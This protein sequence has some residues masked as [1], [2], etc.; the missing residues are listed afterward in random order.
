PGPSND[1]RDA[2]HGKP[3]RFGVTERFSV[4]LKPGNAGEGRTSI[5]DRHIRGEEPGDWV[6]YRDPIH[7]LVDGAA[8][9]ITIVVA[10]SKDVQTP[11]GGKNE[12]PK[13]EPRF[14]RTKHHLGGDDLFVVGKHLGASGRC[15]L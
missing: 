1:R 14:N 6:T 7:K 15:H 10:I 8:F 4:P 13:S 9:I 12:T 5:Q 2:R 3:R 11:M